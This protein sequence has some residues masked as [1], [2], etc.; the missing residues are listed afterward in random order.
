MLAPK[1]GTN[2]V[3]TNGHPGSGSLADMAASADRRYW[4][5]LPYRGRLASLNVQL[6]PPLGIM[7]V[8]LYRM[9]RL[10]ECREESD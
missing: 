7:V 6:S 10:Y 3:D 5:V 1:A 4:T 2:A 8:L 9:S